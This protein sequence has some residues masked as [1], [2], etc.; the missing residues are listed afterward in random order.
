MATEETN[1]P[2]KHV[3]R[4]AATPWGGPGTARLAALI[5]LLGDSSPSVWKSVRRELVAAGPRARPALLRATRDE[6]PARRARARRLLLDAERLRVVGRLLSLAGSPTIDL[7]RA[8]L[9]LSRL[10]DPGLDARPYVRA[11]DGFAERLRPRWTACEDRVERVGLLAGYLGRE[12]GFTGGASD[13]Y[14]PDKVYLH[15]AI[16]RR[17]GMP[18]TLCAIYLFVA[19]R[20]GV[21]AAI[22]PLP[23]HVMLRV[24]SGDSATLLDPFHRGE[25]RSERECI[26]YLA[27]NGLAPQPGWFRD[28]E[29]SAIFLR[30]SLNLKGSYLRRR[31][32]REARRLDRVVL[33]L[34]ERPVRAAHASRVI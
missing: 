6:Q 28:A 26:E 8:L 1:Q 19:R 4:T 20:L 14:H 10:E 24:Y 34:R 5:E 2:E 3:R 15:R 12:I 13:Y 29:D 11:L 16:E 17:Q 7:E 21:P 27:Q 23:G 22:V 25:V 18:L 33:A 31:R 32:F 9:L 30:Q